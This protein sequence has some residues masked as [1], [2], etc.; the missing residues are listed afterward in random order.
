MP[1]PDPKSAGPSQRVLR[2]SELIRH[3]AADI[4]ARG[5]IDDPALAKQVV[6]IPLVKM[7]PDLKVATLYVMP[8]GGKGAEKTIAA[9]E[10][11]KKMLRTQ[12]A[13]RINLKFAPDLRFMVDDSFDA[14]AKIDALLKSP[15]VA[16]DLQPPAEG[17]EE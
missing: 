4:L 9:L 3:A 12:I 7:S 10:R 11:N 15:E 5:D 8:L 1:R 2:V 16:R 6:T 13:H 17:G 14:R